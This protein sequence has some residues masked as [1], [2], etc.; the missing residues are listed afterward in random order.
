MSIVMH[1]DAS[2]ER[3]FK[4]SMKNSFEVASLSKKYEVLYDV[5][6]FRTTRGKEGN[7]CFDQ[8][9]SVI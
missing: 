8:I 1:D 5:S 4:T 7:Y 6:G 2:F 3:G 9:M